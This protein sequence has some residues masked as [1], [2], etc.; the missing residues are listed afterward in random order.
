MSIANIRVENP[1]QLELLRSVGIRSLACFDHAGSTP[2]LL[3]HEMIKFV[4]KHQIEHEIVETDI[5]RR[6]KELDQQ[7]EVARNRGLG[8]WY[9]DYKT[10]TEV[11]EK[12]TLLANSAPDIASTFIAGTSHEGRSIYG[13][14]I[15]APGDSSIRPSVLFNGCQH[16]REWVAVMVPVY[17]AEHLIEGWSND[18]EI[19][20]LLESTRVI[21][22]PIVNPDGY[23]YTYAIDGD[24]FWRKNRSVKKMVRVWAL[25]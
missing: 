25:T 5:D 22:V 19:Q 16:A 21:I 14:R 10:W 11:N 18:T 3:D 23:E 17:V 15:T 9:S 12:I 13:I 8:G 6:L 7:R 24:R 2:M 20:S 1:Q 4:K